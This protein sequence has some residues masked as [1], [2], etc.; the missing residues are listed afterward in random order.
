[1]TD[2][3]HYMFVYPIKSFGDID[4]LYGSWMKFIESWGMDNWEAMQ[5]EIEGAI[6]SSDLSVYNFRGDLSYLPKDHA[7]DASKPSY[8]YWGF[9]K[10]KPGMERALEKNFQDFVKLWTDKEMP[11]GWASYQG[12]FGSDMPMYVYAEWGDSPA[13]FWTQVE[14]DEAKTGDAAKA[15]WDQFMQTL[16]SYDYMTGRNRPDL[17]YRPPKEE[18]AEK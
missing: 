16:R 10:V 13:A 11:T 5:K 17:S 15:L 14:K 7:F 2:D 8:I 18:E 6:E 9:C 12:F 4:A 1:M 3:F